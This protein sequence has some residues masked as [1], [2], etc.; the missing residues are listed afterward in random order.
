MVIVYIQ[1]YSLVEAEVLG[2]LCKLI[3]WV[4]D[5]DIFLYAVAHRL[6]KLLILKLAV[7][8]EHDAHICFYE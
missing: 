2:A 6:Q 1:Y 5:N 8:Y 4:T 7:W 3:E